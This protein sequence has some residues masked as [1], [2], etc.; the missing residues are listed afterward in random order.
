MTVARQSEAKGLPLERVAVP[1]HGPG[2]VAHGLALRAALQQELA[3]GD[4]LPV[5]T[6]VGGG[7]R[8][9]DGLHRRKHCG[10]YAPRQA[11]AAR[12]QSPEEM[13]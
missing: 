8:R 1:A 11:G 7:L 2:W 12:V 4:A 3:G 9:E 13:P 6:V 10:Y 5:V